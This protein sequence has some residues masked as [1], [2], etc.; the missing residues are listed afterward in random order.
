MPRASTGTLVPP[1]ADG[2]WRAR[3]TKTKSLPN[4][5]EV[6]TRPLYSLGTTDKALAKRKLA[7][8]VAALEAGHDVL[9]AAESANAPELV[10]EYAEAWHAKRTARGVVMARHE[11]RYL[12][13]HALPAIGH[14]PLCDVTASHVRAVLD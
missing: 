3:V 7:K 14:L 1:A 10:K 8:L 11:W 2:I 4:G 6:T 12:E 13:T 5:E 9:D